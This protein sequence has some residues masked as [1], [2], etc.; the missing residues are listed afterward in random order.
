MKPKQPAPAEAIS[1]EEQSGTRQWRRK[2]PIGDPEDAK[3]RASRYDIRRRHLGDELSAAEEE[4]ILERDIGE[5]KAR[6]DATDK[7]IGRIEETLN[8]LDAG[9]RDNRDALSNL[10]VDIAK[11]PTK[12]ALFGYTSTV[13]A[14][15]VAVIGVFIG[16]LAYLGQLP[17]Q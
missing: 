12:T 4:P 1:N 6:A 8:R 9:L 15:A 16:I 7:A 2:K 11:L 5:L 14:L 10:R 3:P 13:A 17:G